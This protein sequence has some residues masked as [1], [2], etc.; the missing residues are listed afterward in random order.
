MCVFAPRLATVKS[1]SKQG[2][3]AGA[4]GAAGAGAAGAGAAGAGAAGGRLYDR[5]VGRFAGQR[6]IVLSLRIQL[7]GFTHTTHN[8]DKDRNT[9][10]FEGT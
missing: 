6:G 10:E 3:G 7:G 8:A 4:A 1:S 2:A 9:K 5:T